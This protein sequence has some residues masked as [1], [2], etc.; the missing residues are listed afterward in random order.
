MIYKDNLFDGEIPESREGSITYYV[1]SSKEGK[2]NVFSLAL[3][4]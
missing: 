2:R 4:T 1:N 3:G